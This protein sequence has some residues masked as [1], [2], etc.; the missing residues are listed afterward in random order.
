MLGLPYIITAWCKIRT[1]RPSLSQI[2]AIGITE[3]ASFFPSL[4]VCK[5]DFPSNVRWEGRTVIDG[6]TLEVKHTCRSGDLP[7]L[8]PG[9]MF[10]MAVHS[11]VTKL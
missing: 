11:P 1:P 9:L 7:V 3:V 4:I 5:A 6:L 8:V 2:A 10:P